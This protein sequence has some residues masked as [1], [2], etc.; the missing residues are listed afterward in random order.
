[1]TVK[2]LP[3]PVDRQDERVS[4]DTPL[5]T[6]WVRITT[7]LLAHAPA[8]AAAL[9][10]PA[11][12]QDVARA[13]EST[14]VVWPQQ[15]R[16]W[17][18]LHGGWDRDAWAAVLPGWSSPMSLSRSLEE[19]RTWLEVWEDVAADDE[20]LVERGVLAMGQHAGE[21]A[22][23]FLPFFVPLDEDQSGEVLFVDCRPGPRQGC[24]THWMKHDFDHYGL[25]WWS[26]A[27]MLSDVADHLQQWTPCRYWR[28]QVEDGALRWEFDEDA[29]SDSHCL[30]RG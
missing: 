2:S 16:T 29:D 22:G 17:F 24:V 27:Q 6:S 13:E 18:G 1:M 5:E 10:P 15:L 8:T 14:G 26:I 28:P 12:A 19:Q 9:H 20:D 23:A 7:W 11:S 3:S 4:T 30:A 25:G 21:V